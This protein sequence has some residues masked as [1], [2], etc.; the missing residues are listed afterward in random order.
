M[1]VVCSLSDCSDTLV[2]RH[3]L[4]TPH[5]LTETPASDSLP[6]TRRDTLLRLRRAYKEDGVDPP[7]S[8][9]DRLPSLLLRTQIVLGAQTPAHKRTSPCERTPAHENRQWFIFSDARGVP[10]SL[11]SLASS[12]P[13]ATTSSSSA[14]APTTSSVPPTSSQP[15]SPSSPSTTPALSSFATPSRSTT[16]PPFVYDRFFFID[17]FY[18]F[19]AFDAA[20]DATLE[21]ALN[22]DITASF[23]RAVDVY[24][25]AFNFFSDDQTLDYINIC[26]YLARARSN[27]IAQQES[28]AEGP[29]E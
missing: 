2:F 12:S 26:P 10:P 22:D 1:E 7:C 3:R 8:S 5:L 25:R 24:C 29:D 18:I 15:A 14:L 20:I 27:V 11:K 23:E 28:D 17:A 16:T 13:Q 6:C 19:D 21:H 4:A 9:S